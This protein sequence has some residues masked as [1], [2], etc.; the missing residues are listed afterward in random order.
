[1][2]N[3]WWTYQ[4][5]RFPIFGHGPLILAF[6]FCAVGYSRL[7]RGTPGWPAWSSTVVASISCFLL[8]GQLRIA[9]E[10]KDFEEDRQ[11]RPYRPVPRGLITLRELGMVFILAAGLQL[12]LALMLQPALAMVLLLVWAYLAAMSKEFFVRE[13]LKVRPISYMLSH[14]LIMPLTDFYATSCDWLAEGATPP[15]GLFWFLVV[16]FLNGLIIEIG[17][18]IRSPM[19]EEHGVSTYS[20]LWGRKTAV[21]V[22]ICILAMSL[23]AAVLSARRIQFS[24]WVA[25]VLSIMLLFTLIL[26]MRFLRTLGP[27]QG[28]TFELLAGLWTLAV[29]LLLGAIPLTLR[30]V[31]ANS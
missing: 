1:M 17:R 7:L 3:R 25:G 27:K 18:K 4:Q 29:Y 16:S 21:I 14:M 6:S 8:F 13:W 22:W 28:K 15:Q 12:S 19:D 9:D 23:S 24:G 26:A 31:G 30:T 5:E 20:A 2:S 11:F 10:F